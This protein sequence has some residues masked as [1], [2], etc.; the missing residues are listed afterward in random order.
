MSTESNPA[1]TIKLKC[2][3]TQSSDD[4]FS[5]TISKGRRSAWFS[6]YADGN[7]NVLL[8]TGGGIPTSLPFT[9]N[10]RGDSLV[11][12]LQRGMDFVEDKKTKKKAKRKKKA[13]NIDK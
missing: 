3:L 13:S 12:W 2:E 5:L 9:I 10:K 11:V 6:F 7:A 4:S 8:E 1:P